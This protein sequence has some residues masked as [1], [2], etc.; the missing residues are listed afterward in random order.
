MRDIVRWLNEA[1][2]SK[3]LVIG[4]TYY[5][6]KDQ[7]IKAT[8]GHLT[9]SHPWPYPDG[10]LVAGKEFEKILARMPEDPEIF[11]AE[12]RIRFKAGQFRGSVST[13]PLTEWDYAGVEDAEWL[14]IPEGLIPAIKKLRPFISDNATQRW[15]MCVALENGWAYATNNIALACVQCESIGKVMA[16][17][18]VWA[19]DFVLRRTKDLEQWAWAENYVAFRWKNGAWMRSQ[20][21][22][23]HFP[24]RAAELV[25]ASVNESPTQVITDEFREAF[26]EVA[27]LAEDTVSIYHNRIESNFGKAIVKGIAGCEIPPTADCSI[28]G[29]KFLIPAL[30]AA[31][32]WSPSVW[33][34]P[35]PFKGKDI[36]G[37]VVGRRM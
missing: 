3:D 8:N 12:N 37:Y 10:F 36:S 22:V 23:G 30:D 5:M 27:E 31:T 11:L 25:R 24:E 32:H 28:W 26:K 34:K 7:T 15:A 35:A 4:M 19:A 1:L 16:L 17:L 33:P 14:P 13:L 29:A 18:P 9:A 2:D 20:L 21:V 6:V